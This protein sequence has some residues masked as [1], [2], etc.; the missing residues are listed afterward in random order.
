MISS[1]LFCFIFNL[2]AI[3]GKFFAPV[4]TSPSLP[5]FSHTKT[6]LGEVAN[7]SIHLI[8]AL[9]IQPLKI[10]PTT[11]HVP[12]TITQTNPKTKLV[13][14]KKNNKKTHAANNK[15]SSKKIKL[16]T[17][18]QSKTKQPQKTHKIKQPISQN[19]NKIHSETV[20]TPVKLV[21]VDNHA[22]KQ[23]QQLQKK[24]K[25]INPHVLKLALQAFNKA[26]QKG[27]VH[28]PYLTVIDYSLPS[29]EKRM[30]VIDVRNSSVTFHT[31][32]A[33]GKNSGD[34][35]STHFSNQ[36]GSK[37]SSLGTFV[38]SDTY[39]GSVGY[40][41]NLNGLEKGFNDK[42]LSRRVVIHGANYVSEEFLNRFGRMGRSW[43][44]PALER[45]IAPKVINQIKG[46]SVV[47][48]YYP[49][50]EWLNR[51]PLLAA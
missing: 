14:H 42:A 10:T 9:N 17:K 20:S 23:F 40:A 19:T 36:S 50:K 4:E 46:G 32:V 3:A 21:S 29:S 37:A 44:C 18:K 28:K 38:T 34:L 41:L 26:E 13:S 30:W 12:V 1:F 16:I 39:N 35:H 8:S 22:P 47:F 25:Q 6:T 11:T 51:S 49:N 2:G 33:H 24:I 31:Y 15:K 48:A 43:G 7:N 5:T 45:N 27:V